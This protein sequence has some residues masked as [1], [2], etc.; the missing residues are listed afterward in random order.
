MIFPPLGAGE[1]W[2]SGMAKPTKRLRDFFAGLVA[3]AGA[4]L[5]S[6]QAMLIYYLVTGRVQVGEEHPP[7]SVIAV[8]VAVGIFLVFAGYKL[9]NPAASKAAGE[10]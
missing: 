1:T 6:W 9:A 5:V 7:F 2:C 3:L 4:C 10:D 8:L